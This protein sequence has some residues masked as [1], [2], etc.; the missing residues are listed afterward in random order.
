MAYSFTWIFSVSLG[1][2][3]FESGMTWILAVLFENHFNDLKTSHDV[4]WTGPDESHV[5][6]FNS[7]NICAVISV[8]QK[9][10]AHTHTH[11]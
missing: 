2:F 6:D 8:L 11:P 3:L 4:S 9:E 1:F 7:E 5:E 10:H